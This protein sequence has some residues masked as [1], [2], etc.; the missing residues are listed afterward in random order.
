[1]HLPRKRI[2]LLYPMSVKSRACKK[3][4]N[5]CIKSNLRIYQCDSR[6]RLIARVRKCAAHDYLFCNTDVMLT[7]ECKPS[8]LWQLQANLRVKDD[9]AYGWFG[10]VFVCCSSRCLANELQSLW[11]FNNVGGLVVLSSATWLTTALTALKSG[12]CLG[13]KRWNECLNNLPG[14]RGFWTGLSHARTAIEHSDW[15]ATRELLEAA[16]GPLIEDPEN[17]L[18]FGHECFR[19]LKEVYREAQTC[20]DQSLFPI[21]S[22]V[23]QNLSAFRL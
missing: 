8:D 19:L 15:A 6:D 12:K 4:L 5:Q 2:L 11:P 1:M 10:Q 18:F 9:G 16:I 22:L 3:V 7:N 21:L 17:E 23:D 20:G 14:L 13:Q